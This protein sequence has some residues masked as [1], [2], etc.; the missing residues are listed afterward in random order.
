MTVVVSLIGISIPEELLKKID[1]Q[2]GDVTRSKY[3]TR[4]LEEA[5]KQ[6]EKTKR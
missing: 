4:L 2:K 5:I 1:D 6:R 3:I